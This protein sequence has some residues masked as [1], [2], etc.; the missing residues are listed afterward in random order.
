MLPIVSIRQ[1]LYQVSVVHE[2]IK[3]GEMSEEFLFAILSEPWYQYLLGN[4]YM[5]EIPL[6]AGRYG[7]AAP[8]YFPLLPS[9]WIEYNSYF[10][11]WNEKQRGLLLTKLMLRKEATLNNKICMWMLDGVV[12]LT[13]VLGKWSQIYKR[14]PYSENTFLY[15]S[16]FGST[17]KTGS[18]SLHEWRFG[19]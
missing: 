14:S 17:G 4:R 8:W 10:P 18:C 16:L 2:Q 19:F 5:N 11:F 12:I 15:W 7:M 6:L 13:H 9:Y 1:I 3:R